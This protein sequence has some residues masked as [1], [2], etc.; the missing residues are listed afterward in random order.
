MSA[1]PLVI[2]D[3]TRGLFQVHRSV[4]VS[5][6]ILAREKELLFDQMWLYVGHD[7]EIPHPGDFVTRKVGG[8]T[9]IFTRDRS[10]TVRVLLN[11]CRHRGAEVCRE[12]RGNRKVFTCFYHGWAY[13]SDGGLISVPDGDSYADGFKRSEHGLHQP[14]CESYRGFVF[15]TFSADPPDLRAYL[16]D[17]AYLLD[18]VADQ[19]GSGMEIV[20]GT[21]Q[22]AMKANWKL[23]MEN[24]CDG[25]HGFTVHQTYFEMMMNLGVT[26]GLVAAG[27]GRG[28]S[29]DL[30][31]GHAVAESPE[32]GMP[33]MNDDVLAMTVS[34]RA[35]L[36]ERFGEA[37]ARRML[38]TTR[39]TI[40]F[41]NFVVIDLNFGIQVRTM[42]PTAPDHTEITGWQLMPRDAAEALKAYR[43]DNALTFWGPA[44]LAT[45]DD[46]EALDQ[47]QRGFASVHEVPYSDISRGMRSGAPTAV[48]ELQMRTF[49][50]RWN[51]LLTEE[52]AQP[53]GPRYDTSYLVAGLA[54]AEAS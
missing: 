31:N 18:L 15:I 23:L 34:R 8:R 51:E 3:R 29:A 42:Y 7:S 43:L 11:T 1:S 48:D 32:L 27:N 6:E 20:A 40:I 35:A 25:Y 49:W 44:G 53:E 9:V 46:I 10:G 47:C 24:S 4:F 19:S 21:H 36:A 41:P 45:P 12:R 17:A 50:R 39:N 2:D 52:R 26:P 37:H 33:L 30:G 14:H 5:E 54:G 22:Y 38:N 13:G 28:A 16:A